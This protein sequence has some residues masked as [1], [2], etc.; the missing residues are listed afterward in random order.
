MELLLLSAPT[1]TF[2]LAGAHT[3]MVLERIFKACQSLKQPVD[4]DKAFSGLAEGACL[5][6]AGLVSFERQILVCLLTNFPLWVRAPTEFQFGL[7]TSVLDMVRGAPE[8]LHQVLPLDTILASVQICCPDQIPRESGQVLEEDGDS[9]SGFMDSETASESS[10]D[11]FEARTS[12]NQDWSS[13]SRRERL[14]MRGFL[15]E[16]LR[17]LLEREVRQEDGDALI[18]FL[19]SCD[20]TRLVRL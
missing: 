3:V 16:L 8:L 14:H 9:A 20:D 13:M 17:V 11:V 7:V 15:W 10:A 6:Q 19:A 18:H 4:I 2:A 1:R 12:T 5:P